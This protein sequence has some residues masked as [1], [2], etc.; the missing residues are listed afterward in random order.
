MYHPRL[1]CGPKVRFINWHKQVTYTYHIH[2]LLE[3]VFQVGLYD[4]KYIFLS[5]LLCTMFLL[6]LLNK[7]QSSVFVATYL[8]RSLTALQWHWCCIK[9]LKTGVLLHVSWPIS[10]CTRC[11]HPL[12][13]HP[14]TIQGLWAQYYASPHFLSKKNRN[15]SMVRSISMSLFWQYAQ[16]NL[17]CL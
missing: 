14:I 4:N 3:L 16:K 11:A 13:P 5:S 15:K 8:I 12:P 10:M 9:F 6:I 7:H 2:H 17:W 1:S